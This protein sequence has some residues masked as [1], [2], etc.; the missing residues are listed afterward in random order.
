MGIPVMILGES[1]TGK[2]ASLRNVEPHSMLIVNVNRKP[3]A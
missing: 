2:S 3:L 1:G